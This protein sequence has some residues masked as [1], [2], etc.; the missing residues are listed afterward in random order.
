MPGYPVEGALPVNLSRAL[1][2][3]RLEAHDAPSPAYFP[4]DRSRDAL[5]SVLGKALAE[6][7]FVSGFRP[8]ENVID[9]RR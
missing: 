8:S 7:G 4:P 5:V 6:K 9:R 3:L 1:R 2:M